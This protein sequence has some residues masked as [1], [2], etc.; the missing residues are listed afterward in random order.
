MYKNKRL[1]ILIFQ[2]QK[3]L[4]PQFRKPVRR[5]AGKSCKIRNN[6]FQRERMIHGKTA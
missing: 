1:Q 2:F 3:Q 5:Q 4:Q 6:T